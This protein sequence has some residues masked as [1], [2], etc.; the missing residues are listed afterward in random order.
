M[1]CVFSQFWCI[2]I[3]VDIFGTAV[4]DIKYTP[5]LTWP[6]CGYP[7]RPCP[8][9]HPQVDE[10]SLLHGQR[11]APAPH[12][13][14]VTPPQ[15][16]TSGP[17]PT[18]YSGAQLLPQ[19]PPQPRP[20]PSALPP[21]AESHIIPHDQAY[22]SAVRHHRPTA[23]SAETFRP[24]LPSPAVRLRHPSGDAPR[25]AQGPA[26]LPPRPEFAVYPGRGRRVSI[27][28][29]GFDTEF[30]GAGLQTQ[31]KRLVKG[32]MRGQ[33]CYSTVGQALVQTLTCGFQSLNF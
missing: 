6:R 23:P 7:S 31:A 30:A 4:A 32:H 2:G 15:L 28:V 20:V 29:Q 16:Q 14:A 1:L 13:I 25:I 19:H 21:A 10:F 12:A 24:P 18:A 33:V 11:R 26:S 3:Y 17:Q 22:A 5:C 9:K 27:A 8:L